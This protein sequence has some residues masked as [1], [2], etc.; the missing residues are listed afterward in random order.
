VLDQ[1]TIVAGYRID[2]VLGVGGM[3]VV[4]RATQLS[5]NRPA[6]MKVITSEASDDPSFRERFRREG[7]LQ[8]AID[9][10]HIVTVY[11]AGESEHGLFLAMRVV[12]GP[13]LKDLILSGQL[14]PAR[15]VLLLTQV[16]EAL[17]AAHE[18]GLIHRDVKPQNILVGAHDHAYLADFGLTKAPGGSG[19]TEEGQFLG[20]IDYVSPEQARGGNATHCSDIYALTGVLCECLTG[21][22][23]F[24]RPSEPA[25]LYAHMSDPPP[26]ISERRPDLPPALDDVIA[27]GM[28]KDP[29]DRPGSAT[30]LMQDAARAAPAAAAAAPPPAP[31]K[32][33][34]QDGLGDARA[35]TGVTARTAA[36]DSR[37]ATRARA[38]RTVEPSPTP[39]PAAP[40]RR[41]SSVI[42]AVRRLG[43]R[44]RP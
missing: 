4:Y 27:K 36:V 24:P 26:R 9:H 17:D 31:A 13:T 32:E 35:R 30:E 12:R 16:A 21:E 14:D 28:A 38:T 22:V 8:A 29:D 1:G 25:V 20:T 5:L 34:G 44:G 6:A 40:P 39:T 10:P 43:R 42:E 15:A 18:V 33:A 2:G 19:L 11:E 3:A 7:Q 41:W 23:P 37:E